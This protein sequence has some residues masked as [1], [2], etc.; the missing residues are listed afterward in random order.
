MRRRTGAAQDASDL[1]ELDG[2]L[3]GIHVCDLVGES[4]CC[5]LLRQDRGFSVRVRIGGAGVGSVVRFV[6][7]RELAVS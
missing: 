3:G 5:A 4:V 1:D 6:L 7:S 2:D